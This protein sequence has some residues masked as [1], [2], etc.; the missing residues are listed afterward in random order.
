VRAAN[1]E[2]TGEG[3]LE[4]RCDFRLRRPKSAPKRKV[5]PHTGRPD[6]DNLLKSTFDGL[7]PALIENDAAI[8]KVS[9]CKRYALPGEVPG[10]TIVIQDEGE[11]CPTG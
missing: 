6:L 8:V 11:P 5:K 1:P 3:P 4:I 7:V 9:A 2:W 10:A